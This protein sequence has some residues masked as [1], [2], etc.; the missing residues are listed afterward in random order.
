MVDDHPAVRAGLV[1]LLEDETAFT[2]LPSAAGAEQAQKLAHEGAPDI[3]LLDVSLK[4]GHGLRL[5]LELKRLLVAPVV[6]LYT[7]SADPLLEVKAQLVGAD[8]LLPKT[9][10]VNALR[11]A[12]GAASSAIRSRCR[13]TAS[14]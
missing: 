7:A 10:L 11:K 1:A 5:C 8:G 3:A 4:D 6:L 12:I 2:L 9:A 14:S 13:T